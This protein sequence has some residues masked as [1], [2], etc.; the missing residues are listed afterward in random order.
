MHSTQ[1]FTSPT[2]LASKLS[3][4]DI[5]SSSND[6]NTTQDDSPSS[7]SMNSY[8][9]I[10]MD[11]WSKTFENVPKIDKN[12]VMNSGLILDTVK[13]RKQNQHSPEYTQSCYEAIL[14]KEKKFKIHNYLRTRSLAFD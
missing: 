2:S 8:S 6:S 10:M 14:A 12:D 3:L 13:L 7:Q 1:S 9:Q 5:E 4:L 11:R